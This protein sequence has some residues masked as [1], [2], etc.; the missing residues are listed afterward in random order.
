MFTHTRLPSF[1]SSSLSI[2]D[3][4]ISDVHPAAAADV[5]V[6]FLKSSFAKFVADDQTL[7]PFSAELSVKIAIMRNRIL[8]ILMNIIVAFQLTGPTIAR[9][10]D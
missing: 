5:S 8:D 7:F 6:L 2:A 9:M 10:K 4:S 1:F 3:R